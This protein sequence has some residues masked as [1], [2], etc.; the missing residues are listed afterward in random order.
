[1]FGIFIKNLKLPETCGKCIC[2]KTIGTDLWKC[3]L[4]KKE[5]YIWEVGWGDGSD[6]PYIRH[7]DCPLVPVQSYGDLIERDALFK[8][9]E[10]VCTDNDEDIRAVRYNIIKNAPTIIP[11]DE[12]DMDSFIHIFKD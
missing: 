9:C 10:F 12:S 7:K 11:A 4:T 1:M 2:K 6:K 5:F 3:Q 8:K